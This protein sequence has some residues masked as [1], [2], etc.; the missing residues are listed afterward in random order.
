[1]THK[2][3]KYVCILLSFMLF[4][5]L[6]IVIVS[7]MHK[8]D[9]VTTYESKG[10]T[11]SEIAN[12]SNDA[13]ITFS[14]RN[15]EKV[16]RNLIKK[17]KGDILKS[18]VKDIDNLFLY[19]SKITCING[20][21]A[22]T[23]LTE[24]NMDENSISDISPLKNLKNLDKLWLND[25]KVKEISPLKQLDRLT[26]L[27]LEK[28][29]I[30]DIT[31]L[32]NLRKLSKL[33][34]NHN[35]IKDISSLYNLTELE[36]L[37]LNNCSIRDINVISNLDKI[38]I[39][40][41]SDNDINDIG[42][43]GKIKD[44]DKLLCLYLWK[45]NISDISV[46]CDFN[47]LY[48]LSL[49][50]NPIKEYSPIASGYEAVVRDFDFPKSLIKIKVN[51]KYI[52]LDKDPIM[53]GGNAYVSTQ[54]LLKSLGISYS[55]DLKTGYITGIKDARETIKLKAGSK[56]VWIN[57]KLYSYNVIPFVKD[58]CTFIPLKFTIEKLGGKVSYDSK[59]KVF[60]V[61]FK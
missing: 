22:F 21:E 3:V 14:D 24:L 37:E 35:P 53:S 25:N 13:I 48:E 18:D 42:V 2:P 58:G 8:R 60:S 30:S 36:E 38:G 26:E 31:A 45:N 57:G 6:T 52:N 9:T 56:N 10:K 20:L 32:R 15:L 49:D 44:K 12:F 1:M 28:N 51:G 50:K 59:D 7:C 16:I 27:Y 34:L 40:D 17:P 54:Y 46:L 5:L 41:L 39:L 29:E 55:Y 43:L 47:H 19:N 4:F 23:N 33:S 61:T 11:S